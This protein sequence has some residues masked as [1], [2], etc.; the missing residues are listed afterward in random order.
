MRKALLYV[1]I[2][3]TIIITMIPSFQASATNTSDNAWHY[4]NQRIHITNRFDHAKVCG[5]HYCTPGEYVQY[6]EALSAAQRA[7]YGK[8]NPEQHGEHAINN[9]TGQLPSASMHGSGRV[10]YTNS[11]NP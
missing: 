11:T 9:L 8:T 2:F 10:G 7:S 6:T 5:G 3:S 1:G 4:Y